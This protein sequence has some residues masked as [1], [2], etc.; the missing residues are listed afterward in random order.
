MRTSRS[1]RFVVPCLLVI[2]SLLVAR[3]ES[4]RTNSKKQRRE[5]IQAELDQ[6]Q[7]AVKELYATLDVTH[8]DEKDCRNFLESMI[9]RYDDRSNVL[10]EELDAM[11]KAEFKEQ[12]K[13]SLYLQIK[14][15]EEEARQLDATNHP[16]PAK[17]R[18]TKAKS[19]RKALADGS[20]EI[21]IDSEW[22]KAGDADD[23][24]A[25]VQL[26]VELEKLK[27]EA[28]ELRK[29]VTRLQSVVDSSS[30]VKVDRTAEPVSLE[31]N[32]PE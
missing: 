29:E 32:A 11:D 26:V 16:A 20:W 13:Q 31:L 9:Q 30:V 23:I 27:A 17:T 14:R 1:I 28:T 2:S 10:F 18:R 8:A 24:F 12:R 3:G 19:L 25:R 5:T 21:L 15:L 6:N 7:D 4:L 22:S